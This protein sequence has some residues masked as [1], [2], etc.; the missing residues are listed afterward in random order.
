MM[1]GAMSLDLFSVFFG[2]AVALLP[3]FANEILKVGA[4][5]LGCHEGHVVIRRCAHHAGYDA[6]FADGQ[7]MA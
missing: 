5:G 6:F 4:E 7:A 1:I 2:G 3:V